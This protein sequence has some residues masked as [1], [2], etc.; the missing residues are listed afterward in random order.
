MN[1]ETAKY[2][3]KLYFSKNKLFLILFIKGYTACAQGK[4][5][6]IAMTYFGK[7][8]FGELTC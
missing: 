3:R 5:K 1:Q 6:Q 8:Q 7:R 2:R 4:E